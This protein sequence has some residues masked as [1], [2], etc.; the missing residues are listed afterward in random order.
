MDLQWIYNGLATDLSLWESF[1]RSLGFIFERPEPHF[2]P[3]LPYC[4]LKQHASTR[5][6]T[7]AHAS[8]HKHT[9]ARAST[10]EHAQARG[11]RRKHTQATRK[12]HA[13]NT[14]ETRKHT[15]AHASTRR[16]AQ[17]RASTRKHAPA[18]ANTPKVAA[19][20]YQLAANKLITS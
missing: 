1:W 8:T 18:Y 16:H 5:K 12:Q 20:I 7:Q 10:R 9:Q 3:W 19:R 4:T 2:L 17:A 11:S 15:Q 13:R 6:H 14:Q